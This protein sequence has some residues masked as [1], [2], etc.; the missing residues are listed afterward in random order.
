MDNYDPLWDRRVKAKKQKAA[1]QEQVPD[2]RCLINLHSNLT[3]HAGSQTS[4]LFKYCI[5]TKTF[6]KQIK[7]NFIFECW[8]QWHKGRWRNTGTESCGTSLKE[9]RSAVSGSK[10]QRLP[11]DHVTMMNKWLFST[12]ICLYQILSRPLSMT[13]PL[14]KTLHTCRRHERRVKQAVKPGLI[15]PCYS[16]R[17]LIL[18]KDHLL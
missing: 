10:H 12:F 15:C 18:I 1:T 11:N 4:T 13:P 16:L 7:H 2:F 17:L 6:W 3:L 9:W 14:V 8:R 5:I